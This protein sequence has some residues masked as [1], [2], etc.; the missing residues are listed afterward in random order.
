MS[1]EKKQ[2]LD[3][4]REAG[5]IVRETLQAMEAYVREGVTTAELNEIGA[6]VLHRNGARSA[7]KVVYG[8][9]AE[10]GISV[11]EEITH[12]IPSERRIKAG[13]LVKLDV[14][15]E[16]DGYMADAA[17]TVVV[18]PAE[19]E[20]YAL[21][22]C[23]KQAFE[24]AMQVARVGNRVNA[25]GKTVEHT[26][27]QYGFSVIEGYGGHGIGR[28]IHEEP[29][30]PNVYD[31]RARQRLTKGLV[32]AVEPLV[33]MGEGAVYEAEDGWTIKTRDG[34]STAHYEHTVI[35]TKG[36]PLLITA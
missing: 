31:L 24:K 25:I 32:I 16:K 18:G 7:P 1:I 35:I 4:L 23:A 5:R 33:S 26:V 19:D 17:I 10:V 6:A 3:G 29:T 36:A 20:K 22:A 11:N 9:P 21:V 2:D 30:I 15:A 14:V 34:S 13:D 28:S 8:F 12:G 27:K